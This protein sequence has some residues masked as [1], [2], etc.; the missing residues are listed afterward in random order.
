MLRLIVGLVAI[1]CFY[2]SA[3]PNTRTTQLFINYAD[4]SFL[5]SEGF[6]PFGQVI[7]GMDVVTSINAEYGQLP[8]QAQIYSQGNAYLQ[9]H[10][11]ALSYSTTVTQVTVIKE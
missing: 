6:A 9:K 4:N 1:S 10:F 3:G 2:A 11:P 7:E 5:D 8:N